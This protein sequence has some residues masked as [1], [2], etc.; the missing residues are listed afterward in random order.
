MA[1]TS[2]KFPCT[3]CGKTYT[4]KPELAGKKAKCK[5]GNVMMVPA[6]PPAPPEEEDGL[7]DL[8]PAD[9]PPKPKVKPRVPLA[10]LPAKG[11]APPSRSPVAAPVAAVAAATAR[12]PMLAYQR[13]PTQ[14][15]K[16]RFSTATL[17]DMKRDAYVPAALLVGGLLIHVAYYALRYQL[18]PTGMLLTGAGLSL[19]MV[20]KAVLLIGFALVMAGPLGVSFG[21]IWTAALKLAAM[22]VFC[23]GVTTWVDAGVDKMTGT[24][25]GMFSGMLSFPVALCVYWVLLTYLFSMDP[26]D[27][28]LVVMLLAVFD[29]IVR[30]ALLF[31][32]LA[33]VLRLG[34]VGPAALPAAVT[35]AA[36]TTGDPMVAQVADLKQADLLR[37]AKKYIADGHQ[38]ALTKPVDAWYEAGC[39]N[40]WF[41]VSRDINGNTETE[42]VIVELPKDKTKRAR[43]YQIL[44]DHY[45]EFKIP[46]DTEDVTDDGKDSYIVMS[47]N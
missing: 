30:W 31:L 34:G 24:R 7:Y 20:F 3:S 9:E 43:C 33:F 32:L 11:P 23:D 17:I 26:G 47:I 41:E 36:P 22:A 13:G 28:W 40:V 21:G 8:A 6:A 10:P 2:S 27:S 38:S 15:E 37:E 1:D 5:C 35:G 39:K 42:S 16:D 44:K 12:S 18:G 25:G 46:Y 4:W 29:M 45:D 14:R 19:V